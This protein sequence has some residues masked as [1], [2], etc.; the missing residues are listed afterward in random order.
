MLKVWLLF[1]QLKTK[2]MTTANFTYVYKSGSLNWNIHG[3]VTKKN[4][5]KVSISIHNPDHYH[6]AARYQAK[7]VAQ[8]I[9]KANFCHPAVQGAIYEQDKSLVNILLEKTIDLHVAYK[10]YSVPFIYKTF[11]YGSNPFTEIQPVKYDRDYYRMQAAIDNYKNVRKG[12]IKKF[13][14]KE[15]RDANM[16]FNDSICKLSDRL[17]KKGVDVK[18]MV[19]TTAR[20]GI[21]IEITIVCNGVT[22]RAWT[23]VAEG[24]IQRAH[25]RYLV[26]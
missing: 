23:I 20:V 18:K 11:N 15:V 10:L 2:K 6:A 7:A 21:N 14:D 19:I 16:H 12:G 17:M 24:P 3:T 13:M 5:G 1:I 26:K 25:Y 4:D 22:T 9:V 8:E